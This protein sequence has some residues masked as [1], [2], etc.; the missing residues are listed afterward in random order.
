MMN[1]TNS[2][3]SGKVWDAKLDERPNPPGDKDKEK[4]EE[5][6]DELENGSDFE[7]DDFEYDD[8]DDDLE[9]DYFDADDMEEDGVEEGGEGG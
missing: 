8:E 7:D 6:D 1:D 2:P 4:P 9:E 5:A 3:F